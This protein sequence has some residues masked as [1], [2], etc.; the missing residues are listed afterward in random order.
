MLRKNVFQCDFLLLGERQCDQPGGKFMPSI[1]AELGYIV[2]KHLV[3]IGLLQN[4]ELDDAQKKLI[5]EKFDQIVAFVA[6]RDLS[7]V[8]IC[9]KLGFVDEAIEHYR[10]AMRGA[11][12]LNPYPERATAGQIDPPLGSARSKAKKSNG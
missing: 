10:R 8:R 3:A 4:P 11:M 5:E 7:S 12:P 6:P 1:I 2:E 9:E